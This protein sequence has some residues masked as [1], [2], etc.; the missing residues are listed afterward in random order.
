M[1]DDSRYFRVRVSP[2]FCPENIELESFIFEN[3]VENYAYE[4]NLE[5]IYENIDNFFDQKPD[6]Y[7]YLNY[8]EVVA[9]II[10]WFG[11]KSFNPILC[12]TVLQYLNIDSNE[13]FGVDDDFRERSAESASTILFQKK[14][15]ELGNDKGSNVY[16]QD[17]IDEFKKYSLSSRLT[18]AAVVVAFKIIQSPNFNEL[19]QYI[20]VDA[21]FALLYIQK[22]NAVFNKKK[23]DTSDLVQ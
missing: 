21:R 15:S 19:L 16:T 20:I 8:D 7:Y 18:H 10:S 5:M 12:N 3:N 6:S 22:K 1:L 11:I 13:A 2:S 23:E 4:K 9:L 17:A 14:M